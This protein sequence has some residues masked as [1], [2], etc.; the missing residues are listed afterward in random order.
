MSRRYPLQALVHRILIR[1]LVVLAV[2][3]ATLLGA[4]A[5]WQGRRQVEA[6]AIDLALDRIAVIR[7]Q[8]GQMLAAGHAGQAAFDRAMGV[9]VAM[10]LAER[11]GRFAHAVFHDEDGDFYTFHA[12]AHPQADAARAAVGTDRSARPPLGESVAGSIRLDGRPA[13]RMTVPV[14]GLD[15]ELVA[16]LTGVF[17]LSDRAA[18]TMVREPLILAAIGVGVIL[19]VSGLFYPVILRLAR[20]LAGYSGELLEANLE[21]MEVLGCAIAKRDS[22]TDAHNYRVTIYAVRLAEQQGLSATA[23]QSLI[24]GGF[25]HDVGKIGIPDAILLKPGKLTDEEFAEMRTH[26]DHGVD[27]VG[28]AGWLADAMP[29]VS[30]HHEKYAG[31]GYPAR[32]PGERIPLT[33]RIFAIADVFDALGS[34]RP[35]KEPLSFERV[36]AIMTEGRGTHFDPE[37]LD[38]F[39]AHAEDWH[40]ELAG[41]SADELRVSLQSITQRYFNA[42]LAKVL[43]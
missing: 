27:I 33:A 13:I 24:K 9:V 3:L 26:V 25:L 19:L 16:W 2:I 1:R 38:R 5:F 40:A 42:E 10:D 6:R 7:A 8:Y 21:M 22:D 15:G 34:A 41:Q 28:R 32:A 43:V 12:A 35:Y 4:T 18:A 37:L 31:D 30:G 11:G 23:M 20:R 14:A 39:L 17:V 29:I 36:K